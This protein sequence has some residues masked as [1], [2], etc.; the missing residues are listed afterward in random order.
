MLKH[1]YH[2][3]LRRW[4]ENW[5]SYSLKQK[6]CWND[7][8]KCSIWL[9]VRCI[10]YEV[11]FFFF[12]C[13]SLTGRDIQKKKKKE[14]E[15]GQVD[16]QLNG[17]VIHWTI[18]LHFLFPSALLSF[19]SRLETHYPGLSHNAPHLLSHSLILSKGITNR[20]NSMKSQW[21][22]WYEMWNHISSN[23]HYTYS[24][25]SLSHMKEWH[26]VAIKICQ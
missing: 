2:S 6:D 7:V 5:I 20:T 3:I 13:P 23:C 16:G 11:F 12:F 24:I 8:R 4:G 9:H 21:S 17:W 19:F 26:M 25:L 1:V 10:F 22:T 15:K 18:S 14:R